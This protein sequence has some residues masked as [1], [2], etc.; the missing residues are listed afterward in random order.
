MGGEEAV[1]RR[2]EPV[3]KAIGDEAL[4][5]GPIGAGTVAKLAH[6]CASFGIQTVLAEAFTLGDK[7]GVEPLALFRAIRQGATGRKRPFDR[8]VEQFLPGTF[9][10]PA[11]ALRLAH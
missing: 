5:V 3:L 2:C 10:P 4:Y 1:Y 6:N 11:F 8:L 9:D 7:A